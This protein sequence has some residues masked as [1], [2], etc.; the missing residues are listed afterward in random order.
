MDTV[1][2]EYIIADSA[3]KHGISDEDILHA[4]RHKIDWIS[5]LEEPDKLLYIG[6]DIANR[7][8]E[9]IT[10]ETKNGVQ[11]IIHAMKLKPN[12]IRIMEGIKNEQR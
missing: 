8:L 7:N 3:R 6:Y 9:G 11:R 5:P 2:N 10:V 12:F 4:V 1:E